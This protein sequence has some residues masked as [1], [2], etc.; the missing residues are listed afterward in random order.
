M[1]NLQILYLKCEKI[2]ATVLRCVYAL[3]FIVDSLTP[4]VSFFTIYNPN[5]FCVKLQGSGSFNQIY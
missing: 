1:H 4:M 5:V 2:S 3:K